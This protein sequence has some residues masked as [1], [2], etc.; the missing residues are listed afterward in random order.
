MEAKSGP[1]ATTLAP[2][3]KV[4][5]LEKAIEKIGFRDLAMQGKVFW[6]DTLWLMRHVRFE[7]HTGKAVV[8]LRRI[9][10]NGKE[11]FADVPHTIH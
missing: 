5:T 10:L 6:D 3:E 1:F 8:R 7:R 4:P 2:G 11:E 9:A